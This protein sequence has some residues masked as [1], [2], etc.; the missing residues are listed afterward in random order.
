M[1]GHGKYTTPELAESRICA[2]VTP[3]FF[4]MSRGD[5]SDGRKIFIGG[6]PFECGDMEIREDFGKFGGIDDIYLPTDKET[7][8]PRGFGFVTFTD[9]RDAQD[10]ADAMHG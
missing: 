8:K 5:D 7:G 4:T 1:Y 9:A 10:A 2:G 3:P 6:L